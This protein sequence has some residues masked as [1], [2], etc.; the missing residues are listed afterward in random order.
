[1]SFR[2]W[3]GL[4]V[5]IIL[6]I[7]VAF[8]LSFLVRYITRFTE[9]SFAVLISV[10]FI[11]EACSKTIQVTSL[12][13]FQSTYNFVNHHHYCRA[14]SYYVTRLQMLNYSTLPFICTTE[15]ASTE[16]WS[17]LHSRT[18]KH[19]HDPPDRLHLGDLACT[20]AESSIRFTALFCVPFITS[21][22]LK[23]PYCDSTQS[24]FFF[25]R[26]R[27]FSKRLLQ[28]YLHYRHYE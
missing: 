2:F 12:S 5:M 10:I 24:S 7:I 27:S 22:Q 26:T 19:R 21:T 18:S 23:S 20:S 9:E 6:L 28:C 8:D 16:V 25:T 14:C 13:S 11:Y 3:I 17:W 1:M 15:T 4:W